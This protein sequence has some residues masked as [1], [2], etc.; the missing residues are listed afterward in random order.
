MNLLIINHY[1]GSPYYGMEYR[2]YYLAK[3]W[4]KQGHIVTIIAASYSHLRQV[5]PDIKK[6]FQEEI[7]DG[8]KY[9]W[10]NSPK[11]NSALSRI[12]NILSFTLKLCINSKKISK[13]YNPNVV[14]A[15]STYTLDNIPAYKISRLT[16]AKYIYEIHDLWP[17]SPMIIGG[18]SKHH[19]FVKI[20][21]FG[22]DYAYKHVD[23]VIS[24]LWN[25]EEH[26]LERGL[27]IGKFKCI[28][29]GYNPEEWTIDSIYQELPNEHQKVFSELKTK[30][31]VGFAGGFVASG[32]LMTLLESANKCKAYTD[33]HFVL[34]GKGNEEHKLKNYVVS[35]K[36]T[37]VTFLPS[38]PKILIPS[39]IK[40]FS[41]G[42]Y[43]GVH[44]ILHQYGTS[45]NKMTD[46]M[47]SS[48][49]IIQA[50]DE[51]NSFVEQVGCG[52]RTE[53]ENE[54]QVTDAIINI[55]NLSAEQRLEMGKRGKNF[56]I[57]NLKWSTL[58]SNF[59]I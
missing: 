34:V 49:P 4:I 7:I 37:N 30:F 14:I 5:Q 27:G 24:L 48:I 32:A 36:L 31:I 50:I 38:I 51:P 18:Y 54:N 19:P 52:I 22:E 8:I 20:M 44:S 23:R 25:S 6:D 45:A 1:A 35:H 9:V 59:L 15:S 56:A 11:Y 16:G 58:A 39:L 41:V 28:P 17:L 10:F 43:G 40:N 46:Y 12:Y 3:E 2:P 21:Q 55:Y 53:A 57:N 42:Y 33:I 47:L 13:L 26:C 29:N